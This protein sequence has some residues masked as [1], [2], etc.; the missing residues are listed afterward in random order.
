MTKLKIVDALERVIRLTPDLH[1]ILIFDKDGVP[2]I[3]AGILL[4]FLM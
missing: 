1:S 2:L 4:L 3:S